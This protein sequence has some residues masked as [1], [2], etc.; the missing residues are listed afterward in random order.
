M[1]NISARRKRLVST[2]KMFPS[3]SSYLHGAEHTKKRKVLGDCRY[4][5][6]CPQ[7]PH[8]TTKHAQKLNAAAILLV[9]R[10]AVTGCMRPIQFCVTPVLV[11]CESVSPSHTAAYPYVSKSVPT[12]PT[13]CTIISSRSLIPARRWGREAP[14]RP[15]RHGEGLEVRRNTTSTDEKTPNS[16]R[17]EEDQ[18]V[19][20]VDKV[21]AHAHATTGGNAR[22]RR[23]HHIQNPVMEMMVKVY[24]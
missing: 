1:N 8:E 19:P 21:T 18:C 11:L 7:R 14:T 10:S 3:G 9:S 24:S 17:E 5:T 16:I 23:G 20:C 13:P 2:V 15:A 12:A 6:D 4:V 22:R